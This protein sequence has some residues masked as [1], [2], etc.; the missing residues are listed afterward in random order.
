[1]NPVPK[2]IGFDSRAITVNGHRTLLISGEMHYARAPRPLWPALLDRSVACGLNCIA[3]YIFWNVHE[4]RRDVYDFSGDHDLGY[5]IKLCGDR[6]LHVI[7]RLGPYCCAE[8]NYGGFPPYLRDE[9]GLAIRTF[10]EPYLQRVEKYFRHLMAE[11]R[12]YLTSRGGP[13]IL[14]QVENEYSNVAKRYGKAGQRYLA[15]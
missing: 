10:N 11:V 14:V 15:W 9:P 8:W 1:M 6:G 4:P 12:P 5:F 7:L 2:N 3:S 13:V